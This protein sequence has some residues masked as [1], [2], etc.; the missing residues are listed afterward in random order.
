M[1]DN[2]EKLNAALAAPP[3][4]LAGH[5]GGQVDTETVEP[6]VGAGSGVKRPA[7][8]PVEFDRDGNRIVA[9]RGH[10]DVRQSERLPPGYKARAVGDMTFDPRIAYEVAL[11]LD[12]P[13]E[14]FS[15]YGYDADDAVALSGTEL[16]ARTVKEYREE[17]KVSGV[18]FKLK[19]KIQAEDLLTHSYQI[20]TDPDVPASVRADLIKWTAKV[21]GYEPKDSTGKEGGGGTFALNI[22]FAQGGQTVL[23]A[24]AQKE[25]SVIDNEG[26]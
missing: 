5:T 24:S 13:S 1:T 3:A 15:R 25:V 18:G 23:S 8:D 6:V 20:A 4:Y 14:I 17:I 11:D 22:T 2:E 16:F 19:A 9:R 26:A 12:E 7:A 21:A 10:L